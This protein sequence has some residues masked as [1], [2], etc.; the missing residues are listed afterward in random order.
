MNSIT[1]NPYNLQ[2]NQLVSLSVSP[3][4]LQGYVGSPYQH[5]RYV[6]DLRTV[7]EVIL[8]EKIKTPSECVE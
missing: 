3:L 7:E 2:R 8:D 6:L 1:A 4:Y 5:L